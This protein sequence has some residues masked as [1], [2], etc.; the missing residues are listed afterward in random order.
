MYMHLVFVRMYLEFLSDC[1]NLKKLS[2]TIHKPLVV[3]VA[4]PL[5]VSIMLLDASVEMF[6]ESFVVFAILDSSKKK[7]YLSGEYR[8]ELFWRKFKIFIRT[9]FIWILVDYSW[10]TFFRVKKWNRNCVHAPLSE[11]LTHPHPHPHPTPPFPQIW[12]LF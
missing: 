12:I 7:K 3:E 5:D 2:D 1:S 8:G 6:H 4:H 11:R 9:L 10:I